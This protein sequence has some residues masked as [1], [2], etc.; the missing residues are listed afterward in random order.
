M[1]MARVTEV[2]MIV[3]RHKI[4]GF[5][6]SDK[7][8]RQTLEQFVGDEIS[9]HKLRNFEFFFQ[10]VIFK[11]IL[12]SLNNVGWYLNLFM[13]SLEGLRICQKCMNG[14]FLF[15]VS[16]LPICNTSSNL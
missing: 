5:S 13:S 2:R 6:T 1:V 4:T 14:Y 12:F 16:L 15:S 9:K 8:N 11:I 3:P 10:K 7:K